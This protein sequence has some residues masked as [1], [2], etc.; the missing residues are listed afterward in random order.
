VPADDFAEYAEQLQRIAAV[1]GNELSA[2]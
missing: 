2:L 1:V